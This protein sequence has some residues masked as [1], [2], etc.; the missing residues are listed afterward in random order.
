MSPD[1]IQDFQRQDIN[2]PEWA[3]LF[4]EARDIVQ[5]RILAE[6][7]ELAVPGVGAINNV[8]RSKNFVTPSDFDGIKLVG[9]NQS[10]H[11]REVNKMCQFMGTQGIFL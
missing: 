6:S 7:N 2:D 5:S 10:P 8:W 1:V 9:L 11:D 3:F 4:S